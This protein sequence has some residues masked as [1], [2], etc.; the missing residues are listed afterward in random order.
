MY[1]STSYISLSNP[2]DTN[3][4]EGMQNSSQIGEVEC[5]YTVISPFEHIVDITFTSW[6]AFI[7]DNNIYANNGNPAITDFYCDISG[8]RNASA[9]M[10][11]FTDITS[12]NLKGKNFYHI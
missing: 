8:T 1:G 4:K 6:P 11:F 12:D 5:N 10:C 3:C 2:S 9:V 7:P